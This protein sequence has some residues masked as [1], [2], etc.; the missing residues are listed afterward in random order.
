MNTKSLAKFYQGVSAEEIQNFQQF[1]E[2]HQRKQLDYNL[3]KVEYLSCGQGERTILLPPG[4]FGILPPEYG[5][6]SIEHFEKNYKVI[7]PDV[8][9]VR[10]LDEAID[11]LNRILEAEGIETVIVVGGSGAGI[12]AQSYF[13]RNF[14]RV[15]AMVLYN[16]PSPKKERNKPAGLWIIRIFPGFILRPLFMK[17]MNRLASA[18]IPSDA[19]ARFGFNL[20]LLKEMFS[21]KFNKKA[22]LSA[23][24]LAFEF[25]EKDTYKLED[26]KEWKGK[27]LVISAEDDPYFKD[28]DDLVKNLPNTETYTFPKGVGHM[29]PLVHPDK[30]FGLIDKFLQ[31]PLSE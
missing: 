6:R 23:L 28:T 14:T 15:E 7:A 4:G 17:K 26:F 8:S 22:M 21:T 31:Y 12:T 16:T 11:I 1:K 9:L 19:E 27:V 29:A 18:E 24:K 30:F 5:F 3:Q 13:K 25:N 2:T 20:A 10:H